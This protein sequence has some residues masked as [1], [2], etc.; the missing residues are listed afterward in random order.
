MS[1]NFFNQTRYKLHLI[2]EFVKIL[3]LSKILICPFSKVAFSSKI[4]K[5]S[6]FENIKGFYIKH[7]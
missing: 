7:H 3:T 2:A 5:L 6:N 1:A 4:G